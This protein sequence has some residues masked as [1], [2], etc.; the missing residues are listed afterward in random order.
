MDVY[1]KSILGILYEIFPDLVAEII[2]KKYINI[3]R[4]NFIK[5]FKMS[6]NSIGLNGILKIKDSCMAHWIV[7]YEKILAEKNKFDD[8][9]LKN[10]NAILENNHYCLQAW[11]MRNK[12]NRLE[13]K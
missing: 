13:F 11:K 7:T 6:K 4:Q 9:N 5:E 2:F 12:N 10:I 3:T 8:N 1:S